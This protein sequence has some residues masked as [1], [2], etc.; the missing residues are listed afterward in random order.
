MEKTCE[1]CVKYWEAREQFRNGTSNVH[2]CLIP[3]EVC[4][5]FKY[6]WTKE[7]CMKKYP[8][9]VAHLI[10]HS[11]GYFSPQAAANALSFY[12]SKRPFFCEWFTHMAQFEPEKDMWNEKAVLRVQENVVK[13]AFQNRHGH[14]GYMED[15]RQ[16]KRLVGLE[17]SSKGSTSQ[18]LASWF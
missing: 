13:W 11:L 16:A 10:C 14:S 7:V 6:A 15:Y 2:P 8:R 9:L 5:N 12:K 1:D 3:G 4:E 18:M 17:L